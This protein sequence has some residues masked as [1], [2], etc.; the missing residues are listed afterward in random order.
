MILPEAVKGTKRIRNAKIVSLYAEGNFSQ[1]LLAKKFGISQI[2]ISQI[3][4]SNAKLILDNK[5][6]NKVQRI[7]LLMQ[8]LH[9]PELKSQCLEKKDLIDL[10]RKEFESDKGITIDNSKT[11]INVNMPNQGEEIVGEAE[12]N[13]LGT[14]ARPA[15]QIPSE[16]S[17]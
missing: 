14:L 13:N 2:R 10:W 3:I 16:S 15:V 4:K 6:W 11:L 5:D 7:N 17:L 1:D 9:K 8:D 12:S